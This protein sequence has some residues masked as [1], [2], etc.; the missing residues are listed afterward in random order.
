MNFN[1][2]LKIPKKTKFNIDK[3]KDPKIEKC[4]LSIEQKLMW[5]N[6]KQHLTDLS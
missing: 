3:L 1:L 4:K 6:I 5:N 2:R